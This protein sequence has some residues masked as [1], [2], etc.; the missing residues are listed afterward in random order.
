MRHHNWDMKLVLL[1]IAAFANLLSAAVVMAAVRAGVWIVCATVVSALR[2]GSV[3]RPRWLFRSVGT[4]S[5][6]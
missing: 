2:I 6:V 1:W 4:P 5:R 3:V